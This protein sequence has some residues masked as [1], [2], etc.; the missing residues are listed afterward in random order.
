MATITEDEILK[1]ANEWHQCGVE[2]GNDV[3]PEFVPCG[4]NDTSDIRVKFIGNV[5]IA[6]PTL[7][8]IASRIIVVSCP[9]YM[10]CIKALRLFCQTEEHHYIPDCFLRFWEPSFQSWHCCSTGQS[11]RANHVAGPQI[12][13]RLPFPLQTHHSSRVWARSWS[14]T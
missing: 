6:P 14:E 11:R 7:Y 13:R 8:I 2:Q 5:Y 4:P 10:V 9:D 1:I 3:V 12:T